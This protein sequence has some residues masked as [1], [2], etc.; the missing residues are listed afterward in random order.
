MD[1]ARRTERVSGLDHALNG[2][3]FKPWSCQACKHRFYAL[4]EDMGAKILWLRIADWFSGSGFRANKKRDRRELFIY[5]LAGA[6]LAVLI[7]SLM[8]QRAAGG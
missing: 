7:Y 4:R 1:R 3:F 2:M 5:L 8:Q 6:V